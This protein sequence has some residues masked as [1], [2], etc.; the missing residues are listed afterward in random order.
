MTQQRQIFISLCVACFSISLILNSFYNI[1]L[2]AK[3]GLHLIWDFKF[4]LRI[5]QRLYH[6]LR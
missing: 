1:V 3:N 6:I 4:G 2:P 5:N